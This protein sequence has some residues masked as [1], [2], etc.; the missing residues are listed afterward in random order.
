[1]DDWLFDE[2]EPGDHRDQDECQ[3][4]GDGDVPLRAIK[5][6]R[7]FRAKLCEECFEVELDRGHV[8]PDDERLN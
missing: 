6:R 3:R 8:A 2:I 4:C 7:G 5:L 1:M